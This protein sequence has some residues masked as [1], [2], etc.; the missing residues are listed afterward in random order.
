MSFDLTF[1]GSG[2]G[3]RGRKYGG[4][5]V[6]VLSGAEGETV[7]VLSEAVLEF[8]SACS[9]VEGSGFMKYITGDRDLQRTTF[10]STIDS[11]TSTVP[12][13]TEYVYRCAE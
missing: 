11:S 6:L 4:F 2:F 5:F 7:L 1:R 3:V 12:G 8:P 13:G 9:G 10:P